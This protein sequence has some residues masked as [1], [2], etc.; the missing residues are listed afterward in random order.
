LNQIAKDPE[1]GI[2]MIQQTLNDDYF[3][4]AAQ[5]DST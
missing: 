5:F 2:S 4:D 3:S 1:Q